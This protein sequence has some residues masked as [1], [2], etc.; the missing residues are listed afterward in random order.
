MEMSYNMTRI[1][2]KKTTG[3]SVTFTIYIYCIYLFNSETKF[4]EFNILSSLIPA[5]VF[6]KLFSIRK[7]E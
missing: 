4:I 6:K 3:W 5:S 7:Y 2:K 1:V